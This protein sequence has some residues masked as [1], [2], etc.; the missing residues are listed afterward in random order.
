M[1]SGDSK[2][3]ASSRF[4]SQILYCGLDLAFI[5][6]GCCAAY[7]RHFWGV[8]TSRL[9]EKEDIVRALIQSAKLQNTHASHAVFNTCKEM[10]MFSVQEVVGVAWW[11]PLVEAGATA[12]TQATA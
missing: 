3:L 8:S 12:A 4:V 10:Q 5:G 11:L 2:R 1:G 7:R 9:L 6:C